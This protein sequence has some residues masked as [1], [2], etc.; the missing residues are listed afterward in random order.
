M[1]KGYELTLFDIGG[2][3][4]IRDIWSR[5]FQDVFGIVYMVD[6]TAKHRLTEA[7]ENL[8]QLLENEMVS[9]KPILV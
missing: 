6:S 2:G 4:K 7:K 3:K 8:Q 1:F 9:G 5:Y